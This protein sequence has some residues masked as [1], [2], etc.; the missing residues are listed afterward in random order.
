MSEVTILSVE[1]AWRGSQA[2]L[3][4]LLPVAIAE[5]VLGGWEHGLTRVRV[6]GLA[7]V[8]VRVAIEKIILLLLRAMAFMLVSRAVTGSDMDLLSLAIIKLGGKMLG[9]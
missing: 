2:F 7:H 9:R 8:V 4:F 6:P 5:E 1:H 3:V